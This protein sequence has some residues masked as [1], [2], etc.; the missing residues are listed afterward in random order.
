MPLALKNNTLQEVADDEVDYELANPSRLLGSHTNM[1][2]MPSAVQATRIFYGARFMNQ[3][4]P[5]VGGEAP[6]IQNLTLNPDHPEQTFDEEAGK[7]LG[8]VYADQDAVVRKV[9]PDF[10]ELLYPDGTTKRQNLYRNFL[11]NRK[12][13]LHNTPLVV[14][15][16]KVTKGQLLAKSNYTDDQGRMAMGLNARIGIVPYKGASMDDAIVISQGFANRLKSEAAYA[17]RLDY[18]KGVKGGKNHFKALFFDKFGRDQMDKLDDDGVVK[19]GETLMPGDPMILATKPRVISSDKLLDLGDL[20]R[21][22][23]N[24]RSDASETWDHEDP[25]HVVG[26]TRTR[27]GIKVDVVAYQPTKVG[28]KLTLRDGQKSII[29]TIIPDEE[30]PRTE[31]GK[32]L[33]VLLNHLSIPSRVN[34]ATPYEIMLGKVA[35]KLGTP[36]K[37]PPFT[38][39]GER[40]YDLVSAALQEAGETDKERVYDPKADRWLDNPITVGNGYVMKLHHMV[41]GKIGA[42]GQGSYDQWQQPVKGGGEGGQSKRLSG[43]ESM[44]LLSAGAYNVL[45]EGATLRGQKNDEYWRK[46]RQGYDPEAPDVPFAWNKF[47]ALLTG[48]GYQTRKI[49]GKPGGLRLGFF[50]DRDLEEQRPVEVLNGEVVDL[51]DYSPKPGGLFDPKLTTGNRWGMISLP[52][53]IPNPA[54]ERVIRKLLG[55]TE[56]QFRSILA[57]EEELPPELRK[58]IAAFQEAQLNA[59]EV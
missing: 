37:L 47:R 12:S 52:N 54:A 27:N 17:T 18:D 44:G 58:R 25:G 45:R 55:L 8:A 16:D 4:V 51:T 9:D 21:Y 56:N 57:G 19:V 29:S 10:I 20:S 28:D 34:A 42:R 7:H 43:L 24:A 1:I 30:M 48:A 39:Q 2:P 13:M 53:P 31:D 14:K 59:Q 38:E 15:G 46:L 50:T 5:I 49:P 23:K 32:P 6:W 26:V 40:W 33:D 36:L 3:A 41:E 11:F 35:A 22:M